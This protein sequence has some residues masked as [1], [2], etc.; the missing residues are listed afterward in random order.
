[1][2]ES[3][4]SQSFAGR[5]TGSGRR[6]PPTA[7]RPAPPPRWQRRRPPGFSPVPS[8]RP[9]SNA[10]TVAPDLGDIGHIQLITPVHWQRLPACAAQDVEPLAIG[11]HSAI[12]NAGAHHLEEF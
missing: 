2:A 4:S 11:L 10:T 8:T 9:T 5:A 6:W 3:G 12:L 7:P 1:M